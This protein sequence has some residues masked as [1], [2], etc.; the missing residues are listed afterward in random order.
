MGRK[1]EYIRWF[2]EHFVSASLSCI[3]PIW[4]N[5]ILSISFVWKYIDSPSIS[6][7]QPWTA[8]IQSDPLWSNLIQFDPI[9][10]ILF[11]CIPKGKKRWIH[12]FIEHFQ[13]ANSTCFDPIWPNLIHFFSIPKGKKRWIHRF[14][15]H[16]APASLSCISAGQSLVALGSKDGQI[17]VYESS[18]EFKCLRLVTVL[19]HH[20]GAI[21][22]VIFH[23][24]KLLS[25]SDDMSVGIVNI[26][27]EDSS[28]SKLILSK[29]LQAKICTK[30]RKQW[31]SYVLSSLE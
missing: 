8:L 24:G 11:F 2:T 18:N 27:G 9:W 19:A 1:V 26:T 29:L 7:Q 16:F 31:K 15:E 20:T 17:H 22:T 5:L 6:R 10:S 3:G 25:G 21:H 13:L 12:Q 30:Y 14:T 4:S 28:K 23:D